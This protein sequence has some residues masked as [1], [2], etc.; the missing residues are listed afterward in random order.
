MLTRS[1]RVHLRGPLPR[2]ATCCLQSRSDAGSLVRR[3]PLAKSMQ[4]RQFRLPSG[5]LS[6]WRNCRKIPL[7]VEGA[8]FQWTSRNGRMVGLNLARL[9]ERHAERLARG[10]TEQIRMS[11]RTSDFRKIPAQDLQLAA[12]DVYRNLGE[13]LLQNRR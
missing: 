5:R 8:F 2:R 13:W 12:V 3:V 9:I 11:E 10:V 1:N 7:H 6:K 4:K